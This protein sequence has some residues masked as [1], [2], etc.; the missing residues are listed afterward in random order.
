MYGPVSYT[1]LDVYKRQGFNTGVSVLA[2]Q[3]QVQ[4]RSVFDPADDHLVDHGVR[5]AWKCSKQDDAVY[6][7]VVFCDGA[8]QL[9][10]HDPWYGFADIQGIFLCLLQIHC[11]GADRNLSLIHIFT[12]MRRPMRSTVQSVI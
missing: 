1:H 12:I 6:I 11:I 10:A 9:T 4:N 5:T 3:Q 8:K 7:V 2:V